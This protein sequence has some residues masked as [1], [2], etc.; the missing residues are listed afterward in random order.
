MDAEG[1]RDH[2]IERGFED[3]DAV[4]L[5]AVAER[6]ERYASAGREPSLAG[7]LDAFSQL[8]IDEGRN[9][10]E[11]FYGLAL[12]GRYTGDE[13]LHATI[14]SF[15]DGAEALGNL[16]DR[17]G[18]EIGHDERD[19]V[20]DGIG[21]P[22]LGTPAGELPAFTARVMER[23]GAEVDPAVTDAILSDC[24]RDLDDAWFAEAR[25]HFEE[26]GDI[27]A[28][29]EWRREQMMETLERHHSEG[30]PWFVQEITEDVL[31]FVRDHPEIS[32]GVRVGSTIVEVKIPHTTREWLAADD[33][34]E[35]RY[36]YCHCPWVKESLLDDDVTVPAAFCACSAG[37]HKRFW[38][39]VLGRPLTAE[40]RE[41]VLAGD[42]RCT[43]AIHLPDD[44]VPP[45][46]E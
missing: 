34:E 16:H 4:A 24:L 32:T 22:P 17:L 29:L 42:D 5:V 26:H 30:T 7:Q 9:T 35:R 39:V 36:H 43:I 45:P 44:V 40:I 41:S 25:A 13:P 15:L 8:L 1:F 46:G 14:M 20:F 31:E 23:L 6:F 18:E 12:Y 37:F 3:E 11:V 2:L 19:R 27:D 33:D 21:L 38:E 28:L 10:G